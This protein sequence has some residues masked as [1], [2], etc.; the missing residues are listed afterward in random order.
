MAAMSCPSWWA[1]VAKSVQL[2]ERGLEAGRQAIEFGGDLLGGDL[3][4][5]DAVLFG[6]QDDGRPM[7]TPGE[8][9][10]PFLISIAYRLQARPRASHRRR[11][12]MLQGTGLRCVTSR[13]T[14]PRSSRQGTHRAVG[15]V[16]LGH[17][18]ELCPLCLQKHHLHR[19]LAVDRGSPFLTRIRRL[20]LVRQIDKT[21]H[22]PGS[23]APAS[24]GIPSQPGMLRPM[25]T[26]FNVSRLRIRPLPGSN[27]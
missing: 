22:R 14:P 9:G 15:I 5:G 21:H 18:L 8:T 25:C 10:M 27:R 26:R 7:A 1:V 23:A 2:G 12:G 6:V 4:V 24:F 3:V 20:E 13:R 11:R 16:A 19:V 17:D